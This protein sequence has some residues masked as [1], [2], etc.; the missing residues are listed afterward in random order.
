MRFTILLTA[1]LPCFL[2]GSCKKEKISKEGMIEDHFYLKN[3]GASTQVYVEGNIS[4]NKIVVVLHGGPGDGSLHFNLGDANTIA[5]TDFAMAYW[6]QRLA[7]SSQGNSLDKSISSYVDDLKKLL[8]LLRHRYGSDT[9]IFIMAHSWGGLLAVKFLEES[10]QTLV[11]GWIQV[12]GVHNY[13]LNDSL[14]HAYL[15]SFGKQQL[16]AGIHTKEWTEIVNYCENNDPKNNRDVAKKLNSY[17][18][19][20][21]KLISDVHKETPTIPE[22]ITYLMRE[23]NYP[24]SAFLVN[25][26]YNHLVGNVEEQ[27]YNEYLSHNL[28]KIHTPALLLCGKYDFV[29]PSGSLDELASRISSTDIRKY[30]FQN[31]GHSPMFNEPFVFWTTVRD[32]VNVH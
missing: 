30:I 21:N 9:K 6:D 29:C 25:G 11:A 31:S 14:T 10:D 23:Y 8:L 24:M 20:T 5:E 32:W 15:L 27:A 18:N 2:I 13:P 16:T 19:S 28:G 4:S 22:R 7:G 17:A 26:I 1:I 12:D 3:N